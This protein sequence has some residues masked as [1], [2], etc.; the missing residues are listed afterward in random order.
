MH[1]DTLTVAIRG[2]L[3]GK[4]RAIE[5]NTGMSLARP[6]EDA[7]LLYQGDFA[8]GYESGTSLANWGV[9]QGDRR[10]AS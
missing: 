4:M 7:I 6:L 9:E 2:P 10:A 8:A 3:P 5:E 1:G